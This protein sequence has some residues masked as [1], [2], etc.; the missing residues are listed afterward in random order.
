[1]KMSKPEDKHFKNSNG[2]IA[3][4]NGKQRTGAGKKVGTPT[5]TCT[6]GK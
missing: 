5:K 1:M 3:S 4:V 2:V 6:K